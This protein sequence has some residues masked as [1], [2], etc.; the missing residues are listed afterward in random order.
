MEKQQK[1]NAKRFI[2]AYNLIDHTLR[3][4]H[5][6]RRSLSFSDMIRKTV[7]VDYI[8]R[9]YEDE[10]DMSK[11]HSIYNCDFTSQFANGDVDIR[12]GVIN[13][14]EYVEID[15]NLILQNDF[16]FEDLI[17][18]IYYGADVLYRHGFKKQGDAYTGSDEFDYA[19]D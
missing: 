6:I 8:V 16:K 4:R 17:F 1:S 15:K 18:E 7:V 11:K 3:T 13:L 2:N 9:K 5:N 12:S 19:I 14:K 10:L